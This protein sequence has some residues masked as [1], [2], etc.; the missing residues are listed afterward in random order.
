MELCMDT[1]HTSAEYA[2]SEDRYYKL[3]DR[4]VKNFGYGATD[5]ANKIAST[6]LERLTAA[7]KAKM[8]E[9]V[10]ARKGY[11]ENIHRLLKLIAPEVMA[12]TAISCALNGAMNEL[13]FTTVCINAGRYLNHELFAAELRIHDEKLLGKVQKWVTEKHGNLKNRL[14]AA[15]S[16]AKKAGFSTS[17]TWKET[18]LGAV[19]GVVMGALVDTLPD[20]FTAVTDERAYRLEVTDGACALAQSAAKQFIRSHPV[21][22]PSAAPPVPWTG[23]NVGGPV[24]PVVQKLGSVVRTRHRETIANVKAAIKSGQMQPALDALNLVQ[25][26]PW[27]INAQVFNVMKECQRRGFVVDGLPAAEDYPMPVTTDEA[28]AAMDDTQKKVWRLQKSSL[29]AANRALVADRLRYDEDME[30]AEVLLEHD[31]F[32]IPHNLDW[33]GREYPMTSFNFQR[34]DRVRALFL[35]ADFNEP[36]G[37]EGI[38]WLKVHVANCG[39]FGKVSKKSYDERIKWTEDNLDLI[40]DCAQKDWDCGGPLTPE[41]LSFWT[42]ADKPFLFLAACI[43]LTNALA[44]GEGYVCSL[45]AS[46][47][48][49]CS[50]LQH[51]C[52][53]TRA[54][55]GSFVN[56]TDNP[57]P[58]D[59]YTI[60]ATRAFKAMVE[61]AEAG[62]P[63]AKRAVAYDG[64]RRKL[65]KR[66]TM[67]YSYSSGKFGM[68]QQHMDDL[69][70]PLKLEVMQ[71][72]RD[73]HP[74]G[75]EWTDQQ[76]AAR[77]LAG[78][79]HA[80][81]EQIVNKPAKAMEFLQDLAKVMAH[82]GKPLEWVTPVGLPWSNRYHEVKTARVKLWMHDTA[83]R[84]SVADGYSKDIDKKRCVNGVAP[85]FVHACDASHLLLTVLN[86]SKEGIRHFALVHDSF[87]CPPTHAA[88]FQGIIRETFVEMY[89]THD[90]LTEVLER[91]KHDLNEHSSRLSEIEDKR[92]DLTGNLNI[93]E[94][95][96]ANYAF[97]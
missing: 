44:A 91:A 15:R 74:F 39:D 90:V 61:A 55:E 48:G 70:E 57:E 79:I 96:N 51:L 10:V 53:M 28:W 1:Q 64:D 37:A 83:V 4:T 2:A 84:I 26:T 95:L 35:F 97:A 65:C 18:T 87:G 20:M 29:K 71:K 77:F 31:Q 86:A 16:V 12:L 54:E 23:W 82:A 52:G 50:G 63:I 56:L 62:D 7:I 38:Q 30:T 58:E 75:S 9:P 17:N 8:D 94:V 3:H 89:E 34:E 32:F 59:V 73:E 19:G 78:H 5:E 41:A 27:K 11:D 25:A 24:D 92:G 45:P 66:N 46:W 67:T 72:K 36:I 93:K 6:G 76:A 33:R 47:D 22:L 60:V 88:R 81:I 49:S 80:A 85:N 42:K 43:E 69:M 68:A 21:F 40:K 13:P 14:Q